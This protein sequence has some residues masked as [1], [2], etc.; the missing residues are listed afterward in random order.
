MSLNIQWIFPPWGRSLRMARTLLWSNLRCVLTFIFSLM[1]PIYWRQFLVEFVVVISENALTCKLLSKPWYLI[2]FTGW[3]EP[4]QMTVIAMINWVLEIYIAT[5][6]LLVT[7]HLI[8][9]FSFLKKLDIR[10]W[11]IGESSVFQLSCCWYN[12]VNLMLRD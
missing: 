8:S 6:E 1:M 9:V 12:S 3:V 10:I 4:V 7:F 5:F 11:L 2:T